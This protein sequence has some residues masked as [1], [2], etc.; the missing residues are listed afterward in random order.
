MT[1][2]TVDENKRKLLLG[3]TTALGV[4][5]IAGASVPFITSMLPSLSA[6]A[7][8]APVKVDLSAMQEGEQKTTLWRGKPV[9]IIKRNAAQITQLTKVLGLL[10]DP[11]SKIAQ[12]PTYATN[13]YRSRKP[14]YLILLGVCTHLGCTPTY[15]PDRGG[16]DP[17]WPGGFFCSCH[18][19]KFDMAGR[20]FKGV[21]APT[22]LE[23][24]PYYFVDDNTLVVGTSQP[25]PV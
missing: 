19:S 11:Y 14:E 7:E 21:P 4:I 18:G 8:A 20:V 1:T 3:S 9:W 22:N 15:R 12:Q 6:Q 16:I 23:V 17:T 13:Q 10:R 2:D 5:G 24:P 25:E